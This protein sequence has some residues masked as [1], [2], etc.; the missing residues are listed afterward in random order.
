MYMQHPDDVNVKCIYD[1]SKI[2]HVDGVNLLSTDNIALNE[3]IAVSIET[4][5]RFNQ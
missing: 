3:S 2:K 4:T 5:K 1:T